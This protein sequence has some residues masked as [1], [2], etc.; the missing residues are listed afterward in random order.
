L[1]IVASPP[2]DIHEHALKVQMDH[3]WKNELGT[4]IDNDGFQV[5]LQL[6]F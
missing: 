2:R 3:T 6:D 1:E 5:Q 4:D